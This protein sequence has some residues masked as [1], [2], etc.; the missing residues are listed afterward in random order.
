M[1]FITVSRICDNALLLGGEDE[2][3]FAV[4]AKF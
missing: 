2:A 4:I 3:D 1:H